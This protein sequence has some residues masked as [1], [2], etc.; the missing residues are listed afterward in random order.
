MPESSWPVGVFDSGLGGLTVVR[1]LR[2]VLPRESILYLAD[3]ARLPYGTRSAA[4]VKRYAAACAREL[5]N[6]GVKSVVV[7]CNTAS[8]VA[9][10]SLQESLPVPVLGVVRPG[11]HAAAAAIRRQRAEGNGAA[12]VGVLGT[13]GTVRSGAYV[14]ALHDELPDMN[15]VAQPAPLLVPLVEEGWVRGEVPRLALRR[16][17]RPLVDAGVTVVLLGC[18]HYPLLRGLIE[19]ILGEMSPRPVLVVDGAEACARRLGELLGERG[20]SGASS[21]STLRLM[22]T[23]L[24]DSFTQ[25]AERFL[26]APIGEV[27]QVDISV[28]ASPPGA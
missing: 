23:D 12:S 14:R 3:T 22:T 11:A 26:G 19:Q 9:V 13:A 20:L 21:P 2:D 4:T 16:Y 1:A 17:L 10:E 18:T 5:L 15:V 7:A 6:R 25:S 24:T 28:S 27:T 8:S